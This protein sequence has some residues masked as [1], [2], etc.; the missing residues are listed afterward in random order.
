MLALKKIDILCDFVNSKVKNYLDG[1][2]YAVKKIRFMA[3]HS[4]KVLKV[5]QFN[6]IVLLY[7]STCGPMGL[8]FAF[9]CLVD[10]A[11]NDL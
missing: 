8:R 6:A 10:G 5:I 9:R 11:N 2:E 4:S 7:T 3:R 1:R